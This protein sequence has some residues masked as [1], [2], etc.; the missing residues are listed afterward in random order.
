MTFSL[1]NLWNVTPKPEM[2]GQLPQGY[3]LQTALADQVVSIR[4]VVLQGFENVYLEHHFP[5]FGRLCNVR[6]IL[7][8]LSKPKT[9]RSLES[10]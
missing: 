8:L 6:A 1:Q 5:V 2:L 7:G 9:V 4:S 3:T 10:V